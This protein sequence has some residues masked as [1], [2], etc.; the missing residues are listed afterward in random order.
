MNNSRKY[1]SNFTLVCSKK[2]IYTNN[3]NISDEYPKWHS[4]Q[5]LS[6]AF[7]NKDRIQILTMITIYKEDR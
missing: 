3:T 2:N 5:Y 6:K 1:Q 7:E 4:V